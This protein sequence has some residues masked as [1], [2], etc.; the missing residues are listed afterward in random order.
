MNQVAD[1]WKD[2]ECIDAGN[3]EKLERKPGRRKADQGLERRDEEG[4]AP[5]LV[6]GLS[7]ACS[8]HGG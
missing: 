6:A 4:I 2:Y 7:D 5:C 1:Q 3:G 8:L